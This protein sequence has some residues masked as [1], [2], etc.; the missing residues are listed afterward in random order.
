MSDVALQYLHAIWVAAI[1]HRGPHDPAATDAT[2]QELI[3][4]ASPRRLLGRS[5]DAR[6]VGLLWDDPRHFEPR[7]RRYDVGVPIDP[8]DADNVSPPGFVLVTTPGR[9]LTATHVG[10]YDR[11]LDTYEKVIDGPLR[12]DGWTL[13]A[14]P[15]IEVYRNSPSEVD[16]DDLR[17]D[18]YFPVA[19]L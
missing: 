18:V 9:Y 5:M 2:W 4:W 11:I 19:K 1:R 7:D 12:Y 17:T 3:V 15:I 8:Q 6:G 13:L 14:Q 16:E 10:T